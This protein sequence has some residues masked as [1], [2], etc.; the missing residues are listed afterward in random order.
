MSLL[1]FAYGSNMSTEQMAHRCPGAEPIGLAEYVGW[2]FLIN[3]R[4]VATVVPAPG[5]RVVGVLWLTTDEH[6]EILDGYEGVATGN[7]VRQLITV[8][9]LVVDGGSVTDEPVQAIVYVACHDEPGPPRA[10][11]LE[12]VLSGAGEFG[13]PDDAMA[14]I[15]RWAT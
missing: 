5:N 13:L 9:P 15:R 3:Q 2:E 11:Y 4:G 8:Q 7:Y 1:Y 12:R 6:I 14:S 10:G